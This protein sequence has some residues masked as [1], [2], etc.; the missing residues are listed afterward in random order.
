[1]KSVRLHGSADL[2]LHDEPVPAAG[3]GDALVRVT[4]VGICGSDL[5]WFCEAGIGSDQLSQP[6]VLGHEFAGV[7]E[8]G[9]G[10]ELSPVLAM[11]SPRG[12]VRVAVDPAIPCGRCLYCQEGNPNFCDNL[13]FAGHSVN[14]G[15]LREFAPWPARCLYPLPDSLSDADGAM[16]EPLGVAIHSVDLGHVR[17][18]MS[19]SVGGC[20]P[21]GLLILQ[22]ARAAGAT[23]LFATDPLPHRLDAARELGATAIQAGPRSEEAVEVRRAVSQATGRAGVDVAFEAAGEDPAVE[24]AVEAVKPGGRVVITGIPAVDHYTFTASTAR[25]KGLTIAICRRMKHTYPRAIRLV[26]SGQVDVRNLITHH[27]PLEKINEAFAAATR[28]EG[29]KI[30]VDL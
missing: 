28:R 29:I 12:P 3:E 2:R 10:I 21:I 25:R 24:T 7:A 14:D 17:P 30:M 23:Q 22:M 15:G 1:M 5:H 13:R 4:A 19:V 8:A 27:F 26:E 11:R 9:A 18:G 6:L 16:L 20:G